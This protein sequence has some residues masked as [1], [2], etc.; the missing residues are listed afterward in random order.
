MCVI[1]SFNAGQ[2]APGSDD[3]VGAI[4]GVDVPADLAAQL[5][6]NIWILGDTFVDTSPFRVQRLTC[7]RQ[8]HEERLFRL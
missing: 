2:A 6:D 4:G 3:C 5:G 8:F 1:C 7:Y